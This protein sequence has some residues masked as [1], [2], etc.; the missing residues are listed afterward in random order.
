ML[1]HNKDHIE[2]VTEFPCLLG[3]PVCNMEKKYQ[4]RRKYFPGD[5]HFLFLPR[6]SKI[7]PL[8]NVFVFFPEKTLNK[9]ITLIAAYCFNFYLTVRHIKL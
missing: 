4:K 8:K 7:I 6:F 9:V 5:I 3:H 2:F 1:I